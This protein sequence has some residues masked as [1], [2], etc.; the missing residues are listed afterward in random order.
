MILD[1]S[2]FFFC[3]PKQRLGLLLRSFANLVICKEIALPST[4]AV[5]AEVVVEMQVPAKKPQQQQQEK[6]TSSFPMEGSAWSC[7]GRT[8]TL[9]TADVGISILQGCAAVGTEDVLVPGG[10]PLP[11]VQLI[12]R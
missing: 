10:V 2:S 7:A 5:S 12:W 9:Q 1:Q 8:L 6:Q 3:F 4:R 11:N